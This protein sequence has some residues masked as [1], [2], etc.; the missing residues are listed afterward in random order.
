MPVQAQPTQA[1]IFNGENDNR[2]TFDGVPV[3]GAH[4]ISVIESV[5]YPYLRAE[6]MLYD[7]FGTFKK[8]AE[9]LG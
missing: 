4:R 9:V 2:V 5:C 8:M 7:I 6:L 1:E 3:A